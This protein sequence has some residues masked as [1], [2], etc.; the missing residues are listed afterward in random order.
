[1]VKHGLLYKRRLIKSGKPIPKGFIHVETR[2]DNGKTLGWVP[3]SINNSDHKYFLVPPI[4]TEDGTYELV[5]EKVQGGLYGKKYKFLKHGSN[6]LIDDVP[7]DFHG[8][9]AYLANSDIEGIVWWKDDEPIAKIKRVDFG[10]P[11]GKKL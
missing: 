2:P 9:E 3:V 7:T 5:G 4:P 10:I 11:W 1:M 6:I 8:L